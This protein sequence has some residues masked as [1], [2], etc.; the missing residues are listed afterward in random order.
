MHPGSIV[1]RRLDATITRTQSLPI[2][3]GIG[4]K[5]PIEANLCSP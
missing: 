5:V 4:T 3:V 1:L 2:D